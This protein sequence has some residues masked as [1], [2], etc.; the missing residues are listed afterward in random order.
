MVLAFTVGFFQKHIFGFHISKNNVLTE[1]NSLIFQIV[2]KIARVVYCL[3]MKV[4]ER[5]QKL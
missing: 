5:L 1:N 4:M 2:Y 3:P